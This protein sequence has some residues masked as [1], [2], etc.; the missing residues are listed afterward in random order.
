MKEARRGASATRLRKTA[1]THAPSDMSIAPALEALLHD[2]VCRLPSA[3]N[4]DHLNECCTAAAEK[5]GAV[6]RHML[7]R[8]VMNQHVDEQTGPA[9][10]REV[11]ERDGGRLDVRH[12]VVQ[13][14]IVKLVQTSTALRSL[15]L[16]CLGEDAELIAAGN[17]VAMSVSGWMDSVA[18]R[19]SETEEAVVLSSSM[20]LRVHKRCA[21]LTVPVLPACCHYMRQVTMAA[22]SACARS[23]GGS[24]ALDCKTPE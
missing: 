22:V 17:V 14:E 3:L 15:L 6:L 12:D 11:V 10:Y 9:R 13:P 20:G 16:Q 2:G 7:L 19:E 4:S 23:V 18:S 8:Q 21:E 24:L 1:R 5:L